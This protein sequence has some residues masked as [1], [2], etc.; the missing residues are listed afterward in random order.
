MLEAAIRACPER[1]WSDPQK[2]PEWVA[3][4]VVGFWYVAYHVV[5]WLDYYLADAGDEYAPPAPFDR[6][7]MDPAGVLP[8]RAYTKEEVLGFLE[9][10]RARF[11]A[12]I[13]DLEEEDFVRLSNSRQQFSRAELLLYNMRH[14]QHHAA[15]LH[16]L[17]RQMTDSTPGWVSRTKVPLG[18]S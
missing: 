8:E 18:D 11:G 10:A 13:A 3:G 9:R 6:C 7:E 12:A 2:R 5:F 16:L 15:Q 4:N 17:L 1:A 14:V